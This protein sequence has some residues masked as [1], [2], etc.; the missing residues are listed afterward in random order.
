MSI[1]DRIVGWIFSDTSQIFVLPIIIGIVII[2]F[3]TVI[4]DVL[5]NIHIY[6]PEW[7]W[8]GM[9]IPLQYILT[10]G[11][12]IGLFSCG[13]PIGLGIMW[14]RW[15]GGAT[16]F[17]LS[18]LLTLSMGVYYGTD[19]IP[20]ADWLGVIVSAMLMGWIAGSLMARS[21]MRG[22]KGFKSILIAVY[23]AAI[24]G[25]IFT[26]TTYIWYSPSFAMGVNGMS[27]FDNVTFTYFVYGAIYGVWSLLAAIICVV[28]SWF[29]MD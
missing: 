7:L 29:R 3:P 17:L 23:V 24:I 4:S 9:E 11:T 8:G 20:A 13:I 10:I 21:R 18:V 28:Q 2:A 26:C 12:V 22:S 19:F 14:N 5:V 6:F 15:A 1:S 16:G 27:W 25:V